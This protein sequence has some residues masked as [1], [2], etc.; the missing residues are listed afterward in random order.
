MSRLRTALE[1]I[2][3]GGSRKKSVTDRSNVSISEISP[4]PPVRDARLSQ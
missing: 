3:V 4:A 1:L 2:E